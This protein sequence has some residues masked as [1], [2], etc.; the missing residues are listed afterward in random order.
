MLIIFLI[1]I[2]WS[3]GLSELELRLLGISPLYLLTMGQAT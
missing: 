3:Y 1:S 2:F